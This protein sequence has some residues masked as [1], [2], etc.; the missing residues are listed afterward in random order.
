MKIG[1]RLNQISHNID[2]YLVTRYRLFFFLFL[3]LSSLTQLLFV[4]N[5][6]HIVNN[7]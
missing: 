6:V 2:L 3:S 1:V 4:W 5:M 7:R